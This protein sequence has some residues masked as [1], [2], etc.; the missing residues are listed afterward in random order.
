MATPEFSI[1]GAGALGCLYAARLKLAGIDVEL[2]QRPQTY[3]APQ[4]DLELTRGSS[5]RKL[6]LACS[7]SEHAGSIRWLIV[8]TKAYQAVDAVLSVAPR[9]TA[10]S[11]IILLHNGLGVLEQL[12][13]RL[14]QPLPPILL[15]SS[16]QAALRHAPTKLEH[17]GEGVTWLGMGTG[18]IDEAEQQQLT[19]SL[20]T[21]LPECHWHQNIWQ[22]LWIKLAINSVINPLTALHQ[23]KNGTLADQRF[24][25]VISKLIDEFCEVAKAEQVALSMQEVSDQVQQV[26]HNTAGN[27][28][29]MNRD[30]AE[31]RRTEI[32]QITGY[33]LDKASQHQL[34]L[35]THTELYNQIKQLEERAGKVKTN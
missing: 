21:A 33:L 31:G 32:D 24:T 35:P 34:H 12:N 19:A 14:P 25:E 7:S 30:I 4:L 27:Y 22:P 13:Q 8:T 29:S 6:S 10:N 2:I 5:H 1:L 11:R 17:T 9:L 23:C 18:S 28:S 16:T 3:S 26:I 15:G 20:N